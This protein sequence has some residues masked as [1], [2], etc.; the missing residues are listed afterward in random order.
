LLTSER[1]GDEQSRRAK[2]Q[3]TLGFIGADGKLDELSAAL[4]SAPVRADLSPELAGLLEQCWTDLQDYVT[5]DERPLFRQTFAGF[6][7]LS[8]VD[9]FCLNQTMMRER[10]D[11]FLVIANEGPWETICS[12]H[13]RFQQE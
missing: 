9:G 11:G 2:L 6:L 1:T 3:A 10:L 5:P 13:L 8:S 7:P 12:I 4:E